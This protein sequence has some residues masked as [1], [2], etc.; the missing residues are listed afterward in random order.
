M[1]LVKDSSVAYHSIKIRLSSTVRVHYHTA[2]KRWYMSEDGI[3]WTA[4]PGAIRN[5]QTA[6]DRACAHYGFRADNTAS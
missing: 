4:L 2:F 5:A 6:I 3:T 1:A